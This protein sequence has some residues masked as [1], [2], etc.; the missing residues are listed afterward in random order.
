[1]TDIRILLVDDEPDIREVVDVSLGLD[2]N[3]TTRDHCRVVSFA[4]SAG[5]DDAAHGRTDNARQPAQESA[6]GPYPGCFSDSQ[7]SSR[8]DRA[9][10]LAWRAGS[11][12]QAIRSDDARKLGTKLPASTCGQSRLLKKAEMPF[13]V[14]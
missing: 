14:Q 8:R 1:M 2:R 7:D 10:H 4:D 13:T 12:V 9:I 11:A 6:D 5:C 3:F